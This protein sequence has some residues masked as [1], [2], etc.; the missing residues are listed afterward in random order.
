VRAERPRARKREPELAGRWPKLVVITITSITSVACLEGH[1]LVIA[2][3]EGAAVCRR[4]RPGGGPAAAKSTA[5]AIQKSATAA[6]AS[7]SQ[8]LPQLARQLDRLGGREQLRWLVSAQR[9][10]RARSR[11]VRDK[12]S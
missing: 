8:A 9:A 3:R 12:R 5:R 2:G 10:P 7:Q 6:H 1:A 4:W 11:A